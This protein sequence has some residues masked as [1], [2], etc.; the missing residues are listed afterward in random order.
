[1]LGIY[2]RLDARIESVDARLSAEIG[3]V[4]D[5]LSA[6]IDTVRT[7]L[8]SK[9]QEVKAGQAAIRERLVR[10]EILIGVADHDAAPVV[11][12]EADQAS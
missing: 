9:I 12:E 6:E 2:D 7:E 11:E 5:E 4:R 8:S 10:L 3:K 1:M